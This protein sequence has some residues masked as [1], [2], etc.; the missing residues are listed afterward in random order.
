MS[1]PE[2]WSDLAA[3]CNDCRDDETGRWVYKQ[4]D[5]KLKCDHGRK[6]KL[7]MSDYW[8]LFYCYTCY[9]RPF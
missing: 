9:E 5:V 7:E 4:A 6:A 3:G 2:Y 8:R 1:T